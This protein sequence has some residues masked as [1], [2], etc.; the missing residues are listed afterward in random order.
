MHTKYPAEHIQVVDGRKGASFDPPVYGLR[1]GQ[2]EHSLQFLY[3]VA[4]LLYCA[5]QFLACQ[6]DI[7]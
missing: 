3:A 6:D 5:V 7:Q 1:A 4:T 2:A